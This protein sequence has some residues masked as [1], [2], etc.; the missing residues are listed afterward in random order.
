[1]SLKQRIERLED[2]RYQLAKDMRAIIDASHGS[3]GELYNA[4][5]TAA[6]YWDYTLL[7]AWTQPATRE[8]A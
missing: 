5:R 7:V 6:A 4:V 8:P 2:D 1:M 3:D